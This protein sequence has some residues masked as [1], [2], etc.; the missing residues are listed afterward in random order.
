[1]RYPRIKIKGYDQEWFDK[2]IKI[3][4]IELNKSDDEELKLQTGYL[5]R[6]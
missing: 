1:M 2:E 4:I 6:N 5:L 3:R